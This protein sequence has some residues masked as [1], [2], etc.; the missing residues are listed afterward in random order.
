[1]G[2]SSLIQT[3]FTIRELK[4]LLACV[5]AYL[6]TQGDSEI[7]RLRQKLTSRLSGDPLG[8]GKFVTAV[9]LYEDGFST[10]I[11]TTRDLERDGFIE[12]TH[13]LSSQ[14]C[15]ARGLAPGASAVL[16]KLTD[17]GEELRHQLETA[18]AQQT[19]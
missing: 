18:V 8:V 2:D 10:K 19:Q 14:E 6:E 3:H 12:I 7:K 16:Y 5:D 11:G 17:K 9:I 13:R 1:M 4:Q 15:R